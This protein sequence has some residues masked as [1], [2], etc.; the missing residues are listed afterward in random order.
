MFSHGTP[1]VQ[2]RSLL[3]VLCV[4]WVGARGKIVEM[5]RGVVD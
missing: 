4:Q 3:W 5:E 2:L 1:R